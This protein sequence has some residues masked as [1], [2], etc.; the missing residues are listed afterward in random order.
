MRIKLSGMDI[1]RKKKNERNGILF[2]DAPISISDLVPVPRKS[3]NE[4]HFNGCYL[5]Q[6]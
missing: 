1:G 3:I 6:G 4:T 5:R 2:L